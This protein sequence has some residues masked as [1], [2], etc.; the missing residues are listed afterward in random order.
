VKEILAVGGVIPA[1]PTINILGSGFSQPDGVAVDVSG[2]VFVADL[3]NHLVKEILAVGGVTSSSSTVL[4]LG[5]GFSYPF[6]VA[7]SANGN[8]FIGDPGSNTVIEFDVADAPALS[9]ASTAVGATSSDSPQTVT[10]ENT[11]NA[12]L[13]FVT[14]STGLNPSISA[15]F[16]LGNSSTCPQLSTSSSPATL[17]SGASCTALISF[18]PTAAGTITGTLVA[19]DDALNAAAPNYVTQ[20]VALSGIATG[21]P[22]TATTAIASTTLTQYQAAT[23]FM[24][25]TASG[26]TGTLTYSVSPALPAG[27][28]FS[29]AGMV[30]GTPTQWVSATYTVTVTDTNGGTATATFSLAVNPGT[31]FTATTAIAS[32]TLT[33]GQAATAFTPVTA[34]GGTGTLSYSVSPALPAG[35][36]FST[37]GTV[38][39]TPTAVS[40][41]TTYTVTVTDSN[42]ATRTATFSLTVTAAT[43]SSANF[44]SVPVATATP[45]TQTLTFTIGAGGTI[46]VPLVLTQGAPNLDF[47]DAGTGTCT[48]NGTSYVYSA[49]ATCTVVVAFT[50]KHPGQRLG[51]VVLSDS[52]GNTIATGNLQGVGT[53]PQVG[54]LPGVTG[55]LSSGFKNPAGLAVDG[56]GNVFVA[57]YNNNAVKEI[58]AVGGVISQNPTIRTLGSGFSQPSGVAVDGSGNVFVTDLGNQAVKEIVAVGGVIPANP[59][60]RTLS[61][62]FNG[63]DGL[64]V[65]GSGNVFVANT[66]NNTVKEIVAVGGVIPANPTIRTLGSGFNQPNGVAVDGNGNVFVGDSNN[67]AVKEIVA[68]GGVIPANP[69]IITLGSGFSSPSS[70]T[71]DGSG[72]V[73]VADEGNIAVKEIVAV[74]GVIPANPTII[75]LGSG[76]IDPYNLAVDS[77]GNVFVADLGNN[78]VDEIDIADAPS[79]SFAS[80]AVGSTSSDSPQTVT[81][82]NTGNAPLTFVTPETGTNLSISANFTLGN[83]STCPQLSTS[84]SPATLASG[85]SCTALISFTPTA[86]G[87]HSGSLVLTDNSLNAIGPSYVTQNIVLSGTGVSEVPSK[88][89]TSAVPSTVASGGNLG[90]LTATIEDASSNT[91]TTS[92]AVV[93][94]TI[95]GPN[96]YTH[97]VTATAVN[98]VASLNLSSLGL[99][100]VGTYTVTTSS[101]GLPPSTATVTVTAGAASQLAVSA[102]PSTL[103]S[104]G[105]LGTLAATI[106]D[107]NGNP[108]TTSTAVVTTTITGPNGY[109]HTVTGNAVNGVASL[110]LSSLGLSAVGTYTVTTSSEGLPPSIAT[111]TVTAGAAS[112]LAVS[113]PPATLVSGGNLGTLA[114]TIKDANGNPVTTST[115]VV[116]TTITGPNGYTHTVTGN[117]VNGVA[118]LNL[119]SLALNSP[120]TYTVTTSSEGLPPSIATVTVT[121]GA[122]SQL[123]LGAVP[124]SIT[125]GQSLGTTTA[126]IEDANGNTVTN[127]SVV[128]TAT[129]TGPNGFSEVVT[130]TAVNG[131]V[132]LNLAPLNPT[133]AGTYTLT[134]S[135]PGLT[136]AISTITVAAQAQDFAIA[137]TGGTPSVPVVPGATASFTLALTPGISGF[138][139]AITLTATGLPAGATYSFSPAT[140]TPGSAL[141]NSVLTVQTT[142]PVATARNLG[143]AAGITFALLFLPLGVLRKKREALKKIRLLSVLG[144]LLLL[145]GVAGLSGCGTSNGFF[146]Q[147]AQSYTVTV[148][149]T[150][151]TLIHSTTVV[152]NVQ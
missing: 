81:V 141:A 96:G 144:V 58:V 35:L 121:A 43:T 50:P 37:T 142:K 112:Q 14:P 28:T 2:N 89:A 33:A 90:T 61:N 115:A 41:A 109:T 93:T 149:G 137:P 42:S 51:A 66:F 98:G 17:A 86:A 63:P 71:V 116:T 45:P 12:P 140:V 119:A 32:T 134:V 13:T 22:I 47:T 65:D 74:G 62:G 80:T 53:G 31:P 118:S 127:S 40:A 83:S 77:S 117:A 79:L 94:T 3:A 52:S 111:V 8:L 133:A 152:L 49:G 136:P 36:V 132:T 88:L 30:S 34:S 99:S 19:Q 150:S 75:T 145:G 100:A 5:S 73:F 147:P 151:G 138:S 24:P 113:A 130:G 7:L 4:T 44:G 18:T 139:G 97:T 46:G 126:T 143:G 102:P 114:A 101:E 11:G 85:A 123:I 135:G 108:V 21:S 1:N 15:D 6:G 146:G 20:S 148:T 25:V 125:P 70:V 110:N 16:S 103:A 38:S 39:G 82:E 76:F 56:S 10:L 48:T 120:G 104:G 27:L 23:A 72:N 128:V 107:A 106:E 69:T 29:S 64:A 131:I 87:K 9:F 54:F 67:N 91:V 78:A 92:T 26:G 95:T 129:L 68:V 84:S 57:D 105:N 122:A 55:T 59:T 124:T 60:V